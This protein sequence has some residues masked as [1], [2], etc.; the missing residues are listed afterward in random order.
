MVDHTNSDHGMYQSLDLENDSS[1]SSSQ[2][3]VVDDNGDDDDNFPVEEIQL[4]G[5]QLFCCCFP[6]TVCCCCR[7]AGSSADY[8]PIGMS[9]TQTLGIVR[10]KQWHDFHQVLATLGLGLAVLVH[11]FEMSNVV[12]DGHPYAPRQG[13]IAKMSECD[14]FLATHTTN[15]TA[16]HQVEEKTWMALVG[17]SALLLQIVSSLSLF[18][19]HNF[20]RALVRP[21]IFTPEVI[22]L[23]WAAVGMVLLEIW[24]MAVDALRLFSLAYKLTLLV[25]LLLVVFMDSAVRVWHSFQIV[26]TVLLILLL[27]IDM[28]LMLLY[29][30]TDHKLICVLSDSVVITSFMCQRVLTINMLTS[31]APSIIVLLTNSSRT[32]M[33]F[34]EVP[35]ERMAFASLLTEGGDGEAARKVLRAMTKRNAM[36]AEKL[37]HVQRALFNHEFGGASSSMSLEESDRLRTG[38]IVSSSGS[39]DSQLM[40]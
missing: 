37:K 10:Y 39:M 36:M 30:R 29:S 23:I 14:I 40:S 2:F 1:S 33:R 24:L 12:S 27:S 16:D 28:L 31:L 6:S 38:R 13:D 4:A 9:Y 3:A 17:W 25:E 20:D 7:P 35:V 26:H 8:N 11:I 22:I 19:K 18:C 15:T 32:K 21:I 5:R 34:A